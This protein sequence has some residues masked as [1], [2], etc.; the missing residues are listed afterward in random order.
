M[1]ISDWSSDVCSSDLVRAQAGDIGAAGDDQLLEARDRGRQLHETCFNGIE[2]IGEITLGPWPGQLHG[3]LRRP[4]GGE[5]RIHLGPGSEHV[6]E[7][8]RGARA[9]RIPQIRLLPAD[10]VNFLTAPEALNGKSV[11]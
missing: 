5:D 8:K 7:T 6:G 11:L 10:P 3:A 4:F 1:R 2:R 9:P